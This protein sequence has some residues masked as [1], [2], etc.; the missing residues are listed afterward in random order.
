MS[1]RL[2]R[3]ERRRP[4]LLVSILLAL[5][6]RLLPPPLRISLEV[7]DCCCHLPEPLTADLVPPLANEL[8]A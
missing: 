2:D 1:E 8:A 6:P 7:D 4:T 5:P 3:A